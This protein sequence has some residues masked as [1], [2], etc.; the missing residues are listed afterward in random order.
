LEE[1]TVLQNRVTAARKR[2]RAE[3]LR[4]QGTEGAV[5]LDDSARVALKAWRAALSELFDFDLQRRDR[6]RG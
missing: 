5:W 6:R 3:L 1:R 4:L 2:Y